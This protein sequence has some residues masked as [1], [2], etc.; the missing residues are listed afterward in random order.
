[1]DALNFLRD[2]ETLEYI[3]S[4]IR[5]ETVVHICDDKYY[6][7]SDNEFEYTTILF[8]W[9]NHKSIIKGEVS[10]KADAISIFSYTK[11]ILK[12]ELPY[13]IK[14]VMS[15]ILTKTFR[16]QVSTSVN[17]HD[18]DTKIETRIL[19]DYI[20]IPMEHHTPFPYENERWNF[21]LLDDTVAG[22]QTKAVR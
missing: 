3:Y 19:P 18:M 5:N 13:K 4:K 2:F 21:N 1:M 11:E 16:V 14:I 20:K 22:S 8:G 17:L 15:E 10:H 12:D 9:S 7:F 6:D